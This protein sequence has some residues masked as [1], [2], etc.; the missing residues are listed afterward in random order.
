METLRVLRA[1]LGGRVV[2]LFVGTLAT[3]FVVPSLAT[4]EELSTDI[5]T[6]TGLILVTRG[7]RSLMQYQSTPA[8]Y[9]VYVKQLW[10]PAGRQVLRDSPHDH[11]HHHALMYA[12][13]AD[14]VDFWGEAPAANPG[15]QIP[16]GEARVDV[17]PDDGL[18]RA[19][20]AQTIDW[21]DAAGQRL[22]AEVRE[23]SVRQH[24]AEDGTLVK[25]RSRFVPSPGRDRSEL[26]GRHYFGW[27]LRMVESM[28]RVGTLFNASGEP[29]KTV[30]G[31]ERLVRADWC[32]Y[33]APVDGRP[34]TIA[35]FDHPDNARH[36]TTWFTMT[37]PFA[38]LS[39]TLALGQQP[40]AVT[41]ESP[42][43]LSYA[44]IVWDGEIGRDQVQRAYDEWVRK[45]S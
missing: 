23:I 32:A 24:V 38:Y 39:A 13:G 37:A 7:D 35:M 42:L 16:R 40:L 10:S 33:T 22:L 4:A 43:V 31:T 1:P 17:L 29:G 41:G 34:V 27:G 26:W 8:P 9:K 6:A 20:I 14:G 44:V 3:V 12:V 36:P 19:R 21:T 2:R 25:W 15:R 5:D 11:V 28:D 45:D 30:R 18:P